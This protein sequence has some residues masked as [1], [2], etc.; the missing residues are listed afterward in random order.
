METS[1]K[2]NLIREYF[3]VI[4]DLIIEYPL[5]SLAAFVRGLITAWSLDGTISWNDAEGLREEL[6]QLSIKVRNRFE[7]NEG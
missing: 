4:D 3:H 5:D 1:R 6:E 2:V 7:N